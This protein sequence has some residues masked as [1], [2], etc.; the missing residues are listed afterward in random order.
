MIR[1]SKRYIIILSQKCPSNNG[2]STNYGEK[3]SGVSNSATG[4][5]GLSV[6]CSATGDN[7]L[8][9]G[10][11]GG[12]WTRKLRWRGSYKWG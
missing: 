9:V 11:S 8:S 6:G 7:G 3:A 5:G 2:D 12:R 10:Y 1:G 4:G